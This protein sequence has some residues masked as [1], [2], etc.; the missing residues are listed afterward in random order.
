MGVSRIRR[1]FL[2]DLFV[3]IQFCKLPLLPK[4]KL[5]KKKH[6]KENSKSGRGDRPVLIQLVIKVVKAKIK[7]SHGPLGS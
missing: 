6:K 1:I 2:I 4:P 5:L 7:C 3:P